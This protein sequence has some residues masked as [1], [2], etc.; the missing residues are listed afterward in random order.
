M[1]ATAGRDFRNHLRACMHFL[2]F[3]SCPADPDVWMRPAIK[4]DGTEV[5]DYVLLYTD[6]TLVISEDAELILRNEIGWYFE[7]KQESIGTPSLYLGGHLRQVELEN[8]VKAWASV[9]LSMFKLQCRMLSS[10]LQKMR[11]RDGISQSRMTPPKINLQ[12]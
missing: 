2:K 5:Y 11:T 10:G 4:S 12:T 6:D 9:P 1:V 7:L 8:G 3:T